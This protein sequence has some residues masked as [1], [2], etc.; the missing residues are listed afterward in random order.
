[1]SQRYK[2]NCLR[3]TGGAVPAREVKRLCLKLFKTFEKNRLVKKGHS[4]H[5]E[6]SD[7]D[8]IVVGKAE[9]KKLNKFYR[10]K[11]RPTDILSFSHQRPQSGLGEL[12]I[13]LPV[14]E[15]QAKAAG[16]SLKEELDMMLIHGF[17]HLLGYD[18]EKNRK[19]ELKMMRLQARLLKQLT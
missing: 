13:C 6:I 18:H 5:P 2:V 8:V 10:K 16:H 4:S 15:K 7:L 12:V 17:L 11:N 1:M 19:E 3:R 14:I 9:S